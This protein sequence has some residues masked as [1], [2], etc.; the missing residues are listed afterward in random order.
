MKLIW[1][2]NQWISC[3]LP[4]QLRER[5]K[6]QNVKRVFPMS[7]QINH[8]RCPNSKILQG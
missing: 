5:I 2:V 4:G 3:F 8:C 6:D 1:Q 7:I